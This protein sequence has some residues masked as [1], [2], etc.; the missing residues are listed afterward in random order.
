M[1][2]RFVRVRNLRVICGLAVVCA[3][4]LSSR[5]GAQLPPSG[6]VHCHSTVILALGDFMTGGITGG[7]S[8][9]V[10]GNAVAIAVTSFDSDDAVCKDHNGKTIRIDPVYP[11]AQV[12]EVV[13][14]TALTSP[15]VNLVSSNANSGVKSFEVFGVA[16]PVAANEVKQVSVRVVDT[17]FVGVNA[18]TAAMTKSILITAAQ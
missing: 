6:Q 14:N 2:Q 5:T 13:A 3:V 15:V 17:A 11:M 12:V 7:P 16:V 8:Q 18:P 4:S 9:V 10:E 1:E